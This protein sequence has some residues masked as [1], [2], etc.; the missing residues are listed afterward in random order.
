[1]K[2]I[3]II[4]TCLLIIILFMAGVAIFTAIIITDYE[5]KI[6]AASDKPWGDGNWNS[7]GGSGTVMLS[8]E[9]T[10]MLSVL[11]AFE[12]NY[13][14]K[15]MRAFNA[16]GSALKTDYTAITPASGKWR[17]DPPP[18]VKIEARVEAEVTL[19][20]G[21][22]LYLPVKDM[23]GAAQNLATA[24]P[25]GSARELNAIRGG[26]GYSRGWF[27]VQYADID[28]SGFSPW[29]PIGVRLK[30]D[31]FTG[32]YDGGGKHI[33]NINVQ[34]T[35]CGSAWG[36]FGALGR[37]GV[38]RDIHVLD[39]SI[40]GGGNTGGICGESKGSV[41]SCSYSGR[42][43]GGD[44]TGGIIGYAEDGGEIDGC[45]FTGTVNS[46]GREKTGGIAGSIADSAA[47]RNC[48]NK[49]TISGKNI[50]GGICGGVSGGA[51]IILSLNSGDVRGVKFVG[52]IAGRGGSGGTITACSNEGNV[53]GAASV[54]GI[55][56]I[57]ENAAVNASRNAGQINASKNFVGGIV[58]YHKQSDMFS[59]YNIG[60]I[61][62]RDDAGGVIGWCGGS[63]TVAACYSAGPVSGINPAGVIGNVT[64]YDR[65]KMF[66]NYWR[67]VPPSG[68][69]GF[70]GTGRPAAGNNAKVFGETSS[71]IMPPDPWPA[72]STHY[73][74]GIGDGSGRGKYWK[75]LGAWNNGV[76][77]V[78]PVLF[79][80]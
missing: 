74:W 32:V 35:S 11:P 44:N 64:E 4:I 69:H 67:K 15:G 2:K 22:T 39:G 34:E 71:L 43:T 37:Y 52:G 14:I 77:P 38:L 66:A 48:T 41:Y 17:L 40:T 10:L 78:F 62:G 25:I 5:V 45:S 33:R 76:N 6:A 47:V 12:Q 28:L 29:Q 57:M 13:E 79:W 1:M 19:T 72:V 23:G 42:V 55:A 68:S 58:G 53:A 24:I 56:G 30:R 60:T 46:T 54:G 59:C 36:L 75:N 63:G 18:V 80:E 51:L 16:L 49:G 8:G 70:Y 31:P 7:G 20:N 61:Q 26:G 65:K 21:S 3:Q 9:G 50:T 73:D 27:Y